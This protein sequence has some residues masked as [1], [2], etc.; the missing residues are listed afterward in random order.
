MQAACNTRAP[1]V[2][3]AGMGVKYI[4]ML[5]VR[6]FCFGGGNNLAW[7]LANFSIWPPGQGGAG[8]PGFFMA[9]KTF[10]F[11]KIVESHP[12]TQKTFAWMGTS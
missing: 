8:W 4:K 6:G 3:D 7:Y 12:G 9:T 11:D 10:I 2:I 5:S 1:A